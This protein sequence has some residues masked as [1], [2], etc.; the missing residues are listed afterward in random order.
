MPWILILI[1]VLLVLGLIVAIYAARMRKD[2]IPDYRT[3]FYMGIVWMAIG[4]P[5]DN[6]ALSGMG[7]AFTI[8]GLVN[9]KKWKKE[10]KWSEL[11]KKEKELKKIVIAFASLLLVAGIIVFFWVNSR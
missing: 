10:K 8:A 2:A 11:S 6:L 5:L 7:V 4:I 9:R 3:F 1:G